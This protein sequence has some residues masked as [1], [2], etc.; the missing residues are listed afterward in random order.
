LADTLTIAGNT[1]KAITVGGNAHIT[2]T[3]ASTALTSFDASGFNGTG[4][5]AAGTGVSWSSGALTNVATI[6]GSA[7]GGDILNA[8]AATKAVTI[9]TIAGANTITGSSI[10][11]T[12]TGGAGN[13]TII[14]G[15]GNDVI[16][17]GGGTDSVTGAAG[18]DLI[19]LSGAKETLVQT[20]GH[21]G[22]NTATTIQ[23]SELTST[24]DIVKGFVAG[25]KIDLSSIGAG[26][27]L[28]AGLTM[29]GTNLAVADNAV[30]FT[31]GT[32]DAAA[33]TFTFAA[34]GLDTAVTYDTNSTAGAGSIAGE[35]I[36]LVGY[37]A[38][39]TTTAAAGII[40][41]A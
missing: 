30:V 18:A 24:F 19:T 21:S 8:S 15:A 12:L 13:D 17:T 4:A 38:A 29:A 32:Y 16:V 26:F 3:A 22:V 10:A 1:V 14:G 5:G 33:G 40:T 34:N 27:Y 9:T 37:H 35:T 7:S 25:D 41:L 2:L 28:T 39:S 23:T 6:T 36:I 11:S 31:S 20:A